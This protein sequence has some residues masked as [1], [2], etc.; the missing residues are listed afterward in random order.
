MGLRPGGERPDL[1]D[2]VLALY[3]GL[4]GSV[5][6]HARAGVNV[7][8]DVGHHDHYSKPL[9][10]LPRCARELVELP[11]LF[12]GVR[13]P[14]EVIWRRRERSWGQSE[15]DGAPE[16]VAAVRRWQEA[17]HALG[18]YDLEVDTSVSSPEQCAERIEARLV[19][20][21][22]GRVFDELARR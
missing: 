19:E 21:P 2:V 14:I 16:L 1:E 22:P 11:V 4:Y 8:V 5:A 7:V 12:V 17:V 10:I 9:G 3:L 18:P 13:C 20:G 15:Q 6:A